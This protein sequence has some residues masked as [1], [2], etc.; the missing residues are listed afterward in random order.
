MKYPAFVLMLIAL[1]GCSREEPIRYPTYEQAMS[2]ATAGT[3]WLPPF[4]STTSRNTVGSFDVDANQLAVEFEFPAGTFD[5]R[6]FG[7]RGI[8]HEIKHEAVGKKAPISRYDPVWRRQGGHKGEG[9]RRADNRD[10]T[11][12]V[13]V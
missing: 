2:E 3:K 12:D 8:A 13:K 5:G 9:L 10:W 11:A 6:A 1:V 7:L 4:L